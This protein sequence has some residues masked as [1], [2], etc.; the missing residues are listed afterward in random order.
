MIKVNDAVSVTAAGAGGGERPSMEKVRQYIW[1]R[2]IDNVKARFEIDEEQALK[3]FEEHYGKH[4]LNQ[5]DECFYYG[6]LLYERA[7]SDDKN[8]AKYLVKSKEVFDIYRRVSG[9]TEWD[10]IEDRFADVCDIIEREG[11]EAKVQAQTKSAPQIEGMVYVPAGTFAFGK[12]GRPTLLSAFYIDVYPVSNQEYK[13]F[14][15]ETKYRRPELW[16][17]SPE[18]AQDELPVTGVSWIDALQFCK[19]AKKSLPTAEQWEKAARGNDSRTYP[20][21][22]EQPTPDRCNYSVE[23]TEPRLLPPKKYEKFKSP[24]GAVA[25]AGSVWEWTNTSYVDEDGAQVLKGGCYADPAHPEYLSVW[26]TNWASKKEK[27]EIIGF[28]CTKS[29]ES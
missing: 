2:Y 9:E 10:V 28:R 12:E 11:L 26:A 22:E 23:G 1:A 25:M 29:L 18:L 14:L 15:E 24:H 5:D 20:W 6:I 8:R 17:R 27:N 3:V 19:W 7:F 16:A 13:R 4:P 21:G